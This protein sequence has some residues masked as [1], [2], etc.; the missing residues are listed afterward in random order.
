MA[1][2]I[3]TAIS[4]PSDKSLWNE[5]LCEEVAFV[6]LLC[7]VTVGPESGEKAAPGA[8]GEP[9]LLWQMNITKVVV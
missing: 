9:N 2:E 3:H 1:G 6:F 4:S 5:I 7:K 8:N